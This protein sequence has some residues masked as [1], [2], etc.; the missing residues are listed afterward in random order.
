MRCKTT[1]KVIL[2]DAPTEPIAGAKVKLFDRDTVT[3]DDLLGT[4]TTDDRGEACF[5]YDTED[6]LDLDDRMGGDAPDLYAVVY[7]ANDEVV[8]STRADTVT[9]RH[10]KHLT[11]RVDR[12]LVRQHNLAVGV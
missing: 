9:D 2:A 11:V 7:D 6:F 12:D 1:V 4:E 3:D 5:N 8:V 10:L